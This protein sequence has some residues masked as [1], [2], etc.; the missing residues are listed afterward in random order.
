MR[1]LGF[2]VL[3]KETN[4]YGL[5]DFL[6]LDSNGKLMFFNFAGD[7]VKIQYVNQKNFIV[8]Q[9]TGLKDKNGKMIYEGDIVK[10]PDWAIGPKNEKVRFSKLSCGFEP[11]V[12]G[13]FECMSPDSEEVEVIGNVHENPELLE[14]RNRYA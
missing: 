14:D 7:N 1:E 12:N 9:Y 3:D 4:D 6:I 8:E 2:R 10:M 5:S 11:F 13:C